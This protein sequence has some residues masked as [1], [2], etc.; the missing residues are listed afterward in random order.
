M[1]RKR[2]Y[3]CSNC[4]RH[5]HSTEWLDVLTSEM[6]V[7]I[8]ELARMFAH[9][10]IAANLP[11]RTTDGEAEGR[12]TLTLRRWLKDGTV[13]EYWGPMIEPLAKVLVER[14]V[15]ALPQDLVG[16]FS[17]IVKRLD[18]PVRILK[19]TAGV[20]AVA[21][22]GWHKGQVYGSE[23][24]PRYDRITFYLRKDKHPFHMTKGKPA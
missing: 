15:V 9:P 1:I 4:R 23:T 21:E 17:R 22:G 19:E 24:D 2:S 12:G 14:D 6:V 16:K 10:A 5:W 7:H 3:T 20:V 8:S 18:L 11:L 13:S